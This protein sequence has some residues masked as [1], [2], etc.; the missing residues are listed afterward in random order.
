MSGYDMDDLEK[1]LNTTPTPKPE[2]AAQETPDTSDLDAIL[3]TTPTPKP[4]KHADCCKAC[5]SDADKTDKTLRYLTVLLERQS[6]MLIKQDEKFDNLTAKVAALQALPQAVAQPIAQPQQAQQ[7]Q[8]YLEW[9][10]CKTSGCTKFQKPR[11][12][13]CSKCKKDRER[14]DNG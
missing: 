5:L 13:S 12:P 8:P 7:A 4:D 3:E 2:P 9:I 6:S 1:I 14:I 11:F 10:P